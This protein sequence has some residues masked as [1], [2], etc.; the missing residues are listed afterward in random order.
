MAIEKR[1]TLFL[2]VGII[3][4]K[5]IEP[6]SIKSRNEDKLKCLFVIYELSNML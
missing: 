2:A 4:E 1:I 5:F 6:Y 3:H